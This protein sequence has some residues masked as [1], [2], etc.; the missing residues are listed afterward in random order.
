LERVAELAFAEARRRSE[1]ALSPDTSPERVAAL[2]VE[3]FKDLPVPPGLAIRL[4]RDGS[5]ERARAVAAEVQRLAP[6]SVTAL[7]FAA[8]IVG[9]FD[10]DPG[11]VDEL[12]DEALD[13]G[14]DPDGSAELAQHM[15]AS[16]RELDAIELVRGM[17]LS[18]SLRTR[19]RR[20]CSAARSRGCTGA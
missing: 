12:L 4:G 19:T 1:E 6:G 2:V 18:T 7:T 3:E 17:L 10:H 20:R 5:E 15:V 13:A 16:G 8:E 11:R 9:V 14:L